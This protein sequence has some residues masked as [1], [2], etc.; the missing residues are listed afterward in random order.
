[1]LAPDWPGLGP[2]GLDQPRPARPG[3]GTVGQLSLGT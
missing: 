3:P 2:P 1:L